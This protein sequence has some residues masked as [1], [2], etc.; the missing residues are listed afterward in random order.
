MNAH[1]KRTNLNCYIKVRLTE[2][3][4]RVHRKHYEVYGITAT[5]PGADAD[6]FRQF[7][8]WDFMSI[9]GGEMGMGFTLPCEMD[10]LVKVYE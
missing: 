8:M 6:G 7:Q 2:H 3:G 4:E 10:V 9:F 5:L 1:F